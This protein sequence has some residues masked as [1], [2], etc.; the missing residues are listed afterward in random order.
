MS[1]QKLRNIRRA[2]GFVGFVSLEHDGDPNA[3]N[4]ELRDRSLEMEM[5]KSQDLKSV[6]EQLLEK[7]IGNEIQSM[8]SGLPKLEKTALQ[9]RLTGI[10]LKEVGEVCGYSESRASQVCK[11]AIKR[12]Q[13]GARLRGLIAA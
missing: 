2:L 8:I 4:S 12:L 11:T 1:A 9:L 3:D 6:E 13:H 5:L 7:Q 10:T